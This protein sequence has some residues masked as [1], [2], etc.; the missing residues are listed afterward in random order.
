MA[1][2]TARVVRSG[3]NPLIG[4]VLEER[5]LKLVEERRDILL[6]A[7]AE[8]DLPAEWL[9]A[10][11]FAESRGR[12]GLKS[13]AGALGL[14]QLVESA[15][16]DAAGRVGIELPTDSEALEE[17]LLEDAALNV[18]LG[19]AHLAWLIEHRGDWSDEAVMVSYNA[20][21]ARL[22]QW[23]EK[24]GSYEGFVAAEEDRVSRGERGTGA[25]SYARQVL[26]AR[27]ALRVRGRLASR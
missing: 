17:A 5:G 3:L 13:S 27:E 16:R 1:A 25:L 11:M 15:A 14:M 19:A 6:S 21:R 24:R 22:F 18:R 9:G 23:I 10:V 8:F 4:S 26:R 7:A 12:S 2:E 20:G